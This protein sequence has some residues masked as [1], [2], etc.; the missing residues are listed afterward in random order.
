MW[1]KKAA[2]VLEKALSPIVPVVGNIGSFIIMAVMLLT[3]ADVFGRRFLNKPVTGSYEISQLV[4]VIIVFTTIAYCQL[5]KG[6]ITI[7]LL[8]SR[9]Q[10][11]IQDVINSIVYVLFLVTFGLLSWQLF[12]Y[13]LEALQKKEVS[14]TILIP[15]YPFAFIAAI[16][17][18]LLC[19]IVLTHLMMFIA[20]A[21]EK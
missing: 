12:V 4:L 1:L 8:V 14:G 3:V 21:V 18:T 7:D 17:C 15:V 11:R 10:R 2:H 20:K 9:L 5:L 19:L 16:G 6:H 13:A